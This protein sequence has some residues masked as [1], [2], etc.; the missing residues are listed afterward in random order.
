[1]QEEFEIITNHIFQFWTKTPKNEQFV[2]VRFLLSSVY[3]ISKYGK[4]FSL[5]PLCNKVYTKVR[6]KMIM[7]FSAL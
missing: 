2:I 7:F 1:M 5:A 6:P 3:M 4:H